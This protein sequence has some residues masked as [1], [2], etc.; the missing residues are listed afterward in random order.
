[1]RK[2][3]LLLALAGSIVLGAGTA[4]GQGTRPG[5]HRFP[6]DSGVH[7]SL[8]CLDCHTVGSR[9]GNFS[10]TGCHSHA[11]GRMSA[12]H[13]AVPGYQWLSAR[14]YACHPNGQV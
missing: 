3:L 12:V 8:G 9:F 10:C 7:R 11:Q 6:I 14:C 5:R 13:S 2:G 1:M 4:I